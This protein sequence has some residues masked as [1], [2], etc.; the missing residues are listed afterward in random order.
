MK[1]KYGKGIALEKTCRKCGY[2]ADDVLSAGV[3][4]TNGCVRVYATDV[5]FICPMCHCQAD[6][7]SDECHAA[8]KSHEGNFSIVSRRISISCIY[9]TNLTMHSS[10]MKNTLSYL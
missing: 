10:C 7:I 2:T 4:E 5:K 6:D 3:H 9:T 8:D 1:E